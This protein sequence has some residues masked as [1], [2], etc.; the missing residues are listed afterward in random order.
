MQVMAYGQKQKGFWKSFFD[1]MNKILG[2]PIT[3]TALT[4]FGIPGLAVDALQFVDHALTELTRNE[5]LVS[6]WKTGSLDFGI[7]PRTKALFKMCPGIWA[8]VDHDYADSSNLLDGHTLDLALGSY[9]L[10]DKTRKA[11]DAN[12]L[13]TDFGFD[14]VA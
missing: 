9:R 8:I 14:A 7:D 1:F 3:A 10:L 13:V 4:G 11:V 2:N 5:G 6:L 12:Y